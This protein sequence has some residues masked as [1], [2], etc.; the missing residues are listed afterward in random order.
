MLRQW[1]AGDKETVDLWKMMNQWVYDGFDITYKELGVDFDKNYYESN[2]YLLGKDVVATGLES[3][4]FY[5]KEDG[6]V[7]IDLTEDGLDEKIVLRSDGTA[8]YITQ[9]IGTAI[10][11]FKDY[12]LSALTYTVGNE[13]D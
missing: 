8:V 1:E 13:Q 6:S 3:G 7:W 10:E 9:D 12:D 2:T 5:R 4:V 11:R